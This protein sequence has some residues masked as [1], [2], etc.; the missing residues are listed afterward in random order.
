VSSDTAGIVLA[1]V[2]YALIG[3]G[4]AGT[5]GVFDRRRS[6]FLDALLGLPLGIAVV[7][8]LSAYAA[9][10]GVAISP[11]ALSL[12]AVAAIAIAGVRLRRRPAAPEVERA[13]RAPLELLLSLVPAMILAWLLCVVT[14]TTAVK[15]LAEWDGWVLWATKARVLYEHPDDGAVIL[16]S[17][18]YGA[19][20][21]PLG[22][23]A[24][25]ATTMRAVGSFDG[26]LL[27]IQLALLVA[28]AVVG[29]W[30]LLRRVAHPLTIGLALL[31]TLASSQLAYQV[32]TNYADVPLAFLTALGVV[33]GAVWLV[34][35]EQRRPWQLVSFTVFLSAAAWTKNEGLL[36]ALAAVAGLLVVTAVTRS[37]PRAALAAAAGFAGLVAPWRVYAAAN[38]LKTYDYDFADLFDLPL[39]RDRADRVDPVARELISEMTAF[40][41][42]G[43]SLALIVLSVATSL[44][45]TRRVAGWYAACWLCFSFCGLIG[46]YWISNHSLDSD[47]GN[48][49]HRTV[50][51]LLVT[52][53]CLTPLLLDDALARAAGT[54]R[55]A[56]SKLRVRRGRLPAS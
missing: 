16:Q 25:E 23:P 3:I 9:L 38:D 1:N 20:S 42:W 50:V 14:W 33:A 39:L 24:L 51:T 30:V 47:L 10:V 49:S 11:A 12:L 26:T 43:L 18:F 46:T 31:A 15:P 53:L 44:L 40:D 6:T 22:L 28:A 2:A 34:D 54:S 36:F 17:S 13:R 37:Q 55:A 27:D 41:S 52:G 19:P 21:Y 8:L 56:L 4:F 48:S 35:A 7:M 32:T 5:I 45:T 29:I